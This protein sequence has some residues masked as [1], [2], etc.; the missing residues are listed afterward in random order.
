M[1]RLFG[2]VIMGII[3]CSALLI[4]NAFA[5]AP[6]TMD[7]QGY[8]TD[9]AGTPVNGSRSMV[10]QL[11]TVSS[12]GAPVWSETQPA[13]TVTNGIYQTI[14]GSVNALNLAFDQTY[15]LGV[16]V[17]GDP[18]MV[19]RQQL[20]SA[21]Y[22]LGLA[23]GSTVT[24]SD[25]A[26]TAT[27]L[28]VTSNSTNAN[29]FSV[30]KTGLNGNGGSFVINEATN[31]FGAVYGYTQG[32]GSAIFGVA[33]TSASAGQFDISGAANPKPAL[34]AQTSGT[35]NAGR[36]LVNN[37]S[38]TNHTVYANT[39]GS[40]YGVWAG[41]ASGIGVYG[42]STSS[43]GVF[44][45]TS[46]GVTGVT[47]RADNAAGYGVYGV[48]WNTGSYGYLGKE[49]G[50]YGN[51]GGFAGVRGQSNSSYGVHGSS[52]S[53]YGVYGSSDSS[54]GVHGNSSSSSGVYGNSVSSHGVYGMNTAATS[55]I[56]GVYGRANNT[57]GTTYGVMGSCAG[58]T[59]YGV[60]GMHSPTSNYGY[61]GTN[62][63]GAYGRN[64]SSG[65][66]G[67]LGGATAGV[68]GTGTIGVYAVNSANA[69][70]N[71]SLATGTYAGD[72][73][74]DI[75]VKGDINREYV[76]GSPKNA[77]PVAYGT[78]NSDGSISGGS[79]NFS[80][81]FNSTSSWYEITITG[82]SYHYTSYTTTANIIGG[83][84][85][86]FATT[87]SVSGRLIVAIFDLSGNRQQNMFNFV[88][89]RP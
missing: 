55:G 76:T 35:G 68:S 59:S 62:T 3:L 69:A 45:I 84:V 28:S 32:T 82:E 7:Y 30:T 24:L 50:V 71:A 43:N 42:S 21:P 22:A 54:F 31:N 26:S 36:F 46:N 20:T 5:D 73:S 9:A 61:L 17:G 12:A 81:T 29:A 4:G 63:Y 64:S 19:P 27:A 80:V 6:K 66:Y 49:Y 15:Y 16:A 70:I 57:T 18:E 11:Y 53:G 33:T 48:N 85:P 89:Y 52:T 8:L 25:S 88:V 79:G 34:L 86:R 65:N 1:A 51:S 87:S 58:S 2:R 74:Y 56:A 78:V 60:Y 83:T 40:G 47:G 44:G 75:R 14:L 23:P 10:F 39:S 67:G 38:S 13:V 72:F 77:V 41:S 37:A